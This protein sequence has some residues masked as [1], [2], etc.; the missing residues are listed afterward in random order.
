MKIV[1]VRT[2]RKR[3]T[4]F[5]AEVWKQPKYLIH[6]Q[7]PKGAEMLGNLV[8]HSLLEQVPHAVSSLLT[9]LLAR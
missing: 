2:E 9:P 1:G 5:S 4:G 7:A 6:H 3:Y 8:K